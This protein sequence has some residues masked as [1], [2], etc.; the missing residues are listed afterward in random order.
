MDNLFVNETIC[1]FRN[2]IECVD[3]RQHITIVVDDVVAE[4]FRTA[5]K[6]L[7]TESEDK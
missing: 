2:A 3:N 1:F 4:Y 7:E 5:I 6:A